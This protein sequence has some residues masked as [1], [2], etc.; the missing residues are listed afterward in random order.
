VTAILTKSLEKTNLRMLNIGTYT[1]GDSGPGLGYS[2]SWIC[3]DL[4]ASAR[5]VIPYIDL[6]F[7]PADPSTD[8]E[9]GSEAE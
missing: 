4:I 2:E 1:D 6:D 9:T 5:N 3:E 8:S 7:W